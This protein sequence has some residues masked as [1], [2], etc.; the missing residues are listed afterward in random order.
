MGNRNRSSRGWRILD[1][2]KVKFEISSFS[3]TGSHR[4]DLSGSVKSK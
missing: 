4:N 2:V 3:S 1:S